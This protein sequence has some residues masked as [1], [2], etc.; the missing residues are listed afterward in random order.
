MASVFSIEK[1]LFERL[2]D[3]TESEESNAPQGW[4]I[5]GK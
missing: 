1:R 2:E 4:S 3:K 5:V